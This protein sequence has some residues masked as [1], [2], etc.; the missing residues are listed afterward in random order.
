MLLNYERALSQPDQRDAVSGRV[1]VGGRHLRLPDRG[2]GQRGRARPLD[3]GHLR[4]D[5]GPGRRRRHRGGGRRPLPPLHA[6]SPPDGGPPPR[7]QP[8]GPGPATPEGLDF[9]RR[10]VDS[11][12]E[13][14]IQ[15]WVTLYHW[16]LPQA[17]QDRG[18]WASRE[19]G[20]RFVEDAA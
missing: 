6:G 8:R 12:L 17:L 10:L 13:R 19:V 18:G 15:P 1:R 11:L 3:L 14:G 5:P 4:R 7:A 9:Y 20:G 16:D 2:G